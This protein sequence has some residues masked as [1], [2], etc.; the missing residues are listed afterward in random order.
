MH[1]N[2]DALTET[3]PHV[4]LTGRHTDVSTFCSGSGPTTMDGILW[5]YV[6]KSKNFKIKWNIGICWRPEVLSLRFNRDIPSQSW[7]GRS[8]EG[9]SLTWEAI[10][11]L[12]PHMTSWSAWLFH[13]PKLPFYEGPIRLDWACLRDLPDGRHCLS[14]DVVFKW[15]HWWFGLC[16]RVLHRNRTVGKGLI[17][18]L[19]RATMEGVREPRKTVAE[20]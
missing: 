9:P 6:L 2:I 17:Q 1:R 3:H 8:A 11:S 12:G 14:E 16:I 20:S 15:D 18:R 4:L 19:G 7:R 10:F 5:N 13:T